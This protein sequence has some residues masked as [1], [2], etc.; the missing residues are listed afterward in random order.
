[1]TVILF[2]SGVPGASLSRPIDLARFTSFLKTFSRDGHIEKQFQDE[3]NGLT[4]IAD[5]GA[6]FGKL[7]G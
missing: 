6:T 7:R 1:M 4:Q 3:V 5:L 2:S